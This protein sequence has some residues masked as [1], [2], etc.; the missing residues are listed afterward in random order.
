MR[1][2]GTAGVSQQIPM[3][4]PFLHG[5]VNPDI[6]CQEVSKPGVENRNMVE[7]VHP[8]CVAIFR[9]IRTVKGR[10]ARPRD[11]PQVGRQLLRALERPLFPHQFPVSQQG[12]T[13][14]EVIR[15]AQRAGG[16]ALKGTPRL[17]EGFLIAQ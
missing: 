3:G 4:L 9:Q 14:S 13:W 12:G 2:K 7:S 11:R 17:V 16:P 8:H 6:I 10:P 15:P 1:Q 5:L